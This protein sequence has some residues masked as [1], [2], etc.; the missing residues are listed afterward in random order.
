V[1]RVVRVA[2]VIWRTTCRSKSPLASAPRHSTTLFT[3]AFCFLGS[4]R[5]TLFFFS[6][7]IRVRRGRLSLSKV[8]SPIRAY[9]VILLFTLNK[10]YFLGCSTSIAS[11]VFC[12]FIVPF[13]LKI[14]KPVLS[15]S[16]RHTYAESVFFSHSCSKRYLALLVREN[17]TL[18]RMIVFLLSLPRARE[19]RA[20][21]RFRRLVTQLHLKRIL[22]IGRDIDANLSLWNAER[23]AGVTG[24][25]GERIACEPLVVATV[26]LGTSGREHLNNSAVYRRTYSDARAHTPRLW[27]L[28]TASWRSSRNAGRKKEKE[29]R[30]KRRRGRRGR[31]REGDLGVR[32]RVP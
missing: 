13:F 14:S 27:P 2:G 15:V 7:V 10:F 19:G 23:L 25:L 4:S 20:R 32:F 3:F 5:A 26:M 6:A 22:E 11:A 30:R 8:N 28:L 1:A 24:W 18:Y 17:R 21:I 12:G 29:E 31:E 9:I 16:T